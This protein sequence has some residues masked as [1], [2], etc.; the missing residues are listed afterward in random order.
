MA[1][2]GFIH[3]AM[4]LQGV[5]IFDTQF[6]KL[7]CFGLLEASDEI[8]IS[9]V[10]PDAE[11]FSRVHTSQYHDNV[12]IHLYDRLD[13]YEYPT[14]HRLQSLAEDADKIWYIHSKG[15]CVSYMGSVYTE[16]WRELMEYYVIEHWEDCVEALD[17]YD[18]CGV[19]WHD[20]PVNHFSGNFWWARGDY[21]KSLPPAN[22]K[23][24]DRREAEFWIGRNPNA[25]VK[26]FHESNVDHYVTQYPRRL[27]E[28][29]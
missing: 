3:A 18:I 10:G 27:Y 5:N 12:S 9:L 11:S 20:N 22:D 25:K 2:K 17:T 26:C 13:V 23:A 29:K 19:N 14:I 6:G 15:A 21:I 7:Q 16:D 24:E 4:T 1:I 28:G 8:H